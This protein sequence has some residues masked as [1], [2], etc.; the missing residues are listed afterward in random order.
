MNLYPAPIYLALG[1]FMALTISNAA[2]FCSGASATQLL[3]SSFNS[4]VS[5]TM[6]P[7]AKNWAKEMPKAEQTD[8]SVEMEGTVF[9]LKMFA[10][11]DSERPLSFASR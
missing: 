1:T 11:V 10:S 4:G 2:C 3:N 9:R 6:S 8:S 5:S 7:S